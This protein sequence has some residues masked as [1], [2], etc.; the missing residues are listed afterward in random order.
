MRKDLIYAASA[1]TLLVDLLAAIAAASCL[2]EPE[3][4]RWTALCRAEAGGAWDRGQVRV[5]ALGHV[6]DPLSR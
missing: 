1:P 3:K 4:N 5:Q 6:P 2:R